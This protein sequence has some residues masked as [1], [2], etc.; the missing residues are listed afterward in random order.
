M[1]FSR[2]V[3][4]IRWTL[5]ATPFVIVIAAAYFL[6]PAL[7][8]RRLQV[9]LGRVSDTFTRL[10]VGAVQTYHPDSVPAEHARFL[11]TALETFCDAL[12]GEWGDFFRLRRVPAPMILQ[13]FESTAQLEEFHRNRFRDEF[14]NLGG[15]Y[16]A[17]SRLIA[18]PAGPGIE[19]VRTVFHEG[20]H[21]VFDLSHSK[22][23]GRLPIWVNE[24]LATYF[25]ESQSGPDG[26]SL[27]GLNVP[28]A[29]VVSD[30][31][32]RGLIRGSEQ[33]VE[34]GPREFQGTDNALYYAAAHTLVAYLLQGE[35]GAYRN[36]F[37]SYYRELLGGGRRTRGLVY[38]KVGK[39]PEEMDEG[40]RRF[41]KRQQ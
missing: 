21:L 31:L 27:G 36:A 2:K 10:D 7:R 37:G 23:I 25:E 15:F 38:F 5:I 13:V 41:I 6:S 30:A 33:I 34:A 3:T 9:D 14:H 32:E 17:G 20:T 18:L 1:S 40:W 16:D 28:M 8:E 24:G 4:W 12:V 11:A 19:A 22:S 29:R 39:Q 26:F 35:E